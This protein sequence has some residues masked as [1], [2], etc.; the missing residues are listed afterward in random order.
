MIQELKIIVWLLPIVFM[1][2]D[3]EEIIFFKS[4][5]NKNK[6]H[7]S[8]KHPI[9]AKRFLPHF[10]KLSTSQFTI[11]VAEEFIIL[12][13]V[14]IFSIILDKYQLWF[15]LFI[16]F[17]IHLIVHIIQWVIYKNYIPA[18]VTS[19]ISLLYSAYALNFIIKNNIFNNTEIILWSFI[20]IV[21][22]IVNLILFHK[23]VEKFFNEK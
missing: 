18:I 3:F 8:T 12:S 9:I 10:E 16:G 4:W 6:K 23:L 20:G 1:F 17:S 19:I 14:T 7:I 5:L 2:H 21:L 13:V 11:I 15:G 22:M